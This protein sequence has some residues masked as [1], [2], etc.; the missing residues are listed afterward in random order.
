MQDLICNTSRD[1]RHDRGFGSFGS[2]IS[3]SFSQGPWKLHDS[4]LQ[5]VN[6]MNFASSRKARRPRGFPHLHLTRAI[7]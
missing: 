5:I 7:G 2:S 3:R 1:S 6:F 4:P